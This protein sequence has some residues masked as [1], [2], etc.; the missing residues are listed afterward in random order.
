MTEIEFKPAEPYF[1]RGC[2]RTIVLRP[3][4]VCAALAAAG[5]GRVV[6]RLLADIGRRGQRRD[7]RAAAGGRAAP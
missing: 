5:P 1:C 7:D 3:C 4:A 2:R 6:D